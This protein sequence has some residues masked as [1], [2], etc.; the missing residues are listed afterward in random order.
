MIH[1]AHD[2]GIFILGF[3]WYIVASY[4]LTVEGLAGVDKSERMNMFRRY[5]AS[6]RYHRLLIQQALVRSAQDSSLLSKVREMERAHSKNF[7]D[8]VGVLKKRGYL[9]EFLVAVKEED[10]ALLKIIEAY[11][12]RM[13]RK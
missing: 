4:E 8:M 6:S 2:S 11:D 13:K 10:A 5:F 1:D 7:V 3:C 12:E 9:E